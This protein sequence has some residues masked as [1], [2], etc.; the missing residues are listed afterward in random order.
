M[1]APVTRRSSIAMVILS[2]SLLA[3]ES[4]PIDDQPPA[5]ATEEVPSFLS[6]ARPANSDGAAIRNKM[7]LAPQGAID[8]EHTF[9]LA[10][11]KRELGKRWFLSAYLK[12]YFPDSVLGGAAET[13]GTRVVSFRIQ[14]GKLFVFDV[15][16][17]K[18][19]S[20]TFDN[21]D[22]VVDAYPI[23]DAEG[24][25]G[26]RSLSDYVVVDP[27]AGLNR[28]GV[29]G[30]AFGAG[31]L[32]FD[33]FMVEV[34]FCQRF[35]SLP[36]GATFE[37]A[38]TGYSDKPNLNGS[39][40]E[41]NF[42]RASGVLGLALRKYQEGEGYTPT[43]VPGQELYF[44]SDP[45]L[46][47]NTG[48]FQQVAIKWNI[49]PGAPPIKWLISPL[50]AQMQESP[51]VK[52]AGIDLV[53]ALKA[54]IESWNTAFGFRAIEAEMASP[55]DS[56]ADDD[57][58]Y[59][60]YDVNDSVGY[61][62]ADWRNNPNTGEVR[63]ASVYFN[64]GFVSGALEVTFPP[65]GARPPAPAD[66]EARARPAPRRALTWGPF[67]RR[68]L[69][70]LYPAHVKLPAGLDLGASTPTTRKEKVEKFIAHVVSHEVGH[71]LG[72][73][74]N[75]K[76]TLVPPSASLMD[77]V[78]D[79]LAVT[80]PVPGPYD[81][82]A[83]RYLYDLAPT[84]PGQPFCT[85]DDIG[86]DP[87]CNMF[88]A[89]DDPLRK[90]YGAGYTQFATELLE[91]GFASGSVDYNL[92]HVVSYARRSAAAADRQAALAIALAPIK[93]PIP[94]EKVASHPTYAPVAN[95]LAQR[96]FARLVPGP[97]PL[98][99]VP[100]AAGLKLPPR[101][102]DATVSQQLAVDLGG[103]VVNLDGIRTFA[104]RRQSVDALKRLQT[105]S[106]YE[107]LRATQSTLRD[108]G[109]PTSVDDQALLD[110]LLA[111]IT[112]ATTPYF[113]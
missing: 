76:G 68:P 106:A 29:V 71:T 43:E 73:R 30:D 110:D 101:P 20:D 55:D 65:D 96:V 17:R 37:Q 64:H 39:G 24:L 81:I 104:T 113:E 75:F 42:F 4:R 66:P 51:E 50:A 79:E 10:V 109:A 3:C 111:R 52:E 23:V 7:V 25:K 77:Y 9:Y 44:R 84:P 12:Q 8:P 67:P 54:G 45:K 108:G 61:A 95:F 92:A 107:V 35:R 103:N 26:S 16:D 86:A 11:H 15:D 97:M 48:S 102:L 90:F 56:F 83:I 36:D 89:T 87:S 18:K 49:H 40:I 63:G 6:V 41:P 5:D 32:G 78:P 85:D 93:T 94:A 70:T 19:D 14:N 99:E 80:A 88:D 53:G 21:P 60:I 2:A 33:R 34:S 62:F 27:S 72:L 105:L 46:I 91:T 100:E 38:F 98:D 31:L 58:N 47:P 69:C 82:D 22:V 1:R 74:H 28:F 59:L 112:R 57:K 13:L